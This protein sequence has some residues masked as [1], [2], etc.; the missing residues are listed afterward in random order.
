MRQNK[1]PKQ[2]DLGLTVSATFLGNTLAWYDYSTFGLIIPIFA[3]IFFVSSNPYLGILLTLLIYAVGSVSRPLGGIIFGIIGDRYGRR[4]SLIAATVCMTVPIFLTG[5]LPTYAQIGIIAPILLAC[6]RFLQGVAVGGEFSSAATYLIESSP[7][8]ERGFFGSF[9]FFGIFAGIS[10]GIIE[11]LLIDMKFSQKDLYDWGWRI[12]FIIGTAMG[13]VTFYLRQKLHE[14]PLFRK[15][16]E[17]ASLVKSPFLELMRTHK[18]ALGQMMGLMV[19]ETVGYNVLHTYF[20]VYMNHFV[21]V[22][23]WTALLLHLVFLL[24]M[25]VFVPL[26]GRVAHFFGCRA[27]ALFG[28]FGFVFFSY[29]CF[30]LLNQALPAL[31]V[32]ALFLMALFF[33]SYL[34]PLPS[35]FS[36]LF[37]TEIRCS[38]IGLGYNLTIA[39]VGGVTPFLNFYL[40]QV[41]KSLL[42]PAFYLMGAALFSLIFLIRLKHHIPH[43]AR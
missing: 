40:M 11:Y 30:G 5:L 37:P 14:S 38:G 25:L 33:A 2:L 23:Y 6:F 7:P 8:R 18:K 10:I 13:Y 15:S 34:A 42:V 28:I 35:F 19:F 16:E 32:F 26:M 41:F 9:V 20:I 43:W 22:S 29:P 12:P 1:E 27:I 31:K 17:Q 3:Q 36:D 39:I 24:L 4:M 21:L